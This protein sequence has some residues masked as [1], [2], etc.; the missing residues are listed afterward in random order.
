MPRSKPK[1]IPMPDAWRQQ[2]RSATMQSNF[3]LGL[4]QPMLAFLS[5]TADDVEWDRGS[6]NDL[7]A[8]NCRIATFRSLEKRGLV[9][10]RTPE[11]LDRLSEQCDPKEFSSCELTPAGRAVVELLKVAGVFVE[12]DASISKKARKA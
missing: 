12:S 3:M 6:F 2:F 4:T 7:S 10:W 1:T 5:A 9:V 11:E 8:P